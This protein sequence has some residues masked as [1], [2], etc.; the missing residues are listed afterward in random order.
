MEK[1][2]SPLSGYTQFHG[3]NV[4]RKIVVI[5]ATSLVVI[6][7]VFGISLFIQQAP[8]STTTL[9]P[10]LNQVTPLNV[11]SPA[12]SPSTSSSGISPVLKSLLT[13]NSKYAGQR[14]P[15]FTLSAIKDYK[16]SS[17][18]MY[19]FTL[20]ENNLPS[21]TKWYGALINEVGALSFY[22][23]GAL[24]YTNESIT[25]TMTFQ[26]PNG[27]YD[28]LA[29]EGNPNIL[30]GTAAVEGSSISMTVNFPALYKATITEQG[31]PSGTTWSYIIEYFSG[32]FEVLNFN[33]TTSTSSVAYLPDGTYSIINGRSVAVVPS[34]S[35]LIVN[36]A[37]VSFTD[38]VPT[39]YKT[40][41]FQSDLGASTEWALSILSENY[42]STYANIS[43]SSSM[44]AYLPN[45]TYVLSGGPGYSEYTFDIIQVNGSAQSVTAVFPHMYKVTFVGNGVSDST[46]EVNIAK[47][48]P[49]SGVGSL[50]YYDYFYGAVQTLYLPNGTYDWAAYAYSAVYQS[51]FKVVGQNMQV[52]FQFGKMYKITFTASNHKASN[53]WEVAVES[54]V[55]S[56]FYTTTN[57][58][59]TSEIYFYLPNGTY[60]YGVSVAGIGN[61]YV[62][63]TVS[64]NSQFITVK[65]PTVYAITFT[66]T[67][68]FPGFQW[69]ISGNMG[70]TFYFD[71]TTSS[72]S[73][74]LY[75][76]NGT[77]N[78]SAF[79][80]AEIG[81][82]YYSL[83]V[84]GGLYTVSGATHT[85]S[86]SF[87]KLYAVTF[88]LLNLR[89]GY[90]VQVNVNEGSQYVDI[91][92][93]SSTGSTM[94]A[95]LYNGTF[96][97]NAVEFKTVEGYDNNPDFST[98]IIGETGNSFNVTGSQLKLAVKLPPLYKVSVSVSG[99]SKG[100][101]WGIYILN[102]NFTVDCFNKATGSSLVFMIPNGSYSAS[103]SYSTLFISSGQ[104]L[105][106]VSGSS[107]SISY[108][109]PSSY[110]VT[111]FEPY[112]GSCVEW[113][114]QVSNLSS[115]TSVAS[116]YNYTHNISL[117]LQNGTYGINVFSFDTY[118]SSY[119][120]TLTVNGAKKTINVIFNNF[121]K[122]DVTETGLPS[123]TGWY[124]NLSNV[125]YFSGELT[126]SSTSF[127]LQNGSYFLT[128][129]A[130][131]ILYFA[132]SQYVNVSGSSVTISVSFSLAYSYKV[133]FIESGL[134]SNTKWYINVTG[135]GESSS[136]T[137]TITVNLPNGTFTYTLSN[138]TDY[139]ANKY[140]GSV[141][142]SGKDTSV[143]VSYL[144]YAYIEGSVSPAGT[145]I[146][147]NGNQ[148]TVSSGSFNASV[149]SGTYHLT[150]TKGG[151][152]TF[153]SNFTLASGH[154][155]TI[156]VTLKALTTTPIKTASSG[157][158]K[159]YIIGGV[160][161]G[162][163]IIGAV[164]FLL[165]RK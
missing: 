159:Y 153:Y 72:S 106:T 161:A 114:I 62:Q 124:M 137:S 79:E 10:D 136:S 68:L 103:F 98:D 21:G 104:R 16:Q 8:V 158:S 11:S 99:L 60:E 110:E 61:S 150:G 17:P 107:T 20:K 88:N 147:I 80:D 92:Q 4:R 91:F 52:H 89:A 63:L 76:S 93:N 66:E 28:F 84:S 73:M 74:V 47:C 86:L 94:T 46:W 43:T 42:S 2:D 125:S 115:F 13:D 111:F 129:E 109:F 7:F 130:S 83:P 82:L 26:V 51:E 101:V 160:I 102:S 56:F 133:S 34:R 118:Y 59:S 30:F 141:T 55:G 157:I 154:T 75:A 18:G 25:S 108:V 143:S 128:P 162:I 116:D 134:P 69:S 41:I 163:V 36:G 135:I 145:V 117:D 50:N 64:G 146:T 49:V 165:R 95:Y 12:V 122:I 105:I 37:P 148:V 142:V 123:G 155:K 70:N 5:I 77:L 19:T 6:S 31:L 119:S 45:G 29:G 39:L 40:T 156:N 53:Q 138:T 44:V 139:Y 71:N 22:Y 132:E 54:S 144:H 32:N 87:P 35:P 96:T 97:Y 27:T 126:S 152:K 3:N 65:L 131:G 23:T 1:E 112:T 120:T 78:Y 57:T 81:T 85:I 127:Y 121:Y 38:V 140:S 58:S 113:G 14:S 9:N 24:Q 67:G 15:Y 33:S 90:S 151:Y 48:S 149:P 164:V 100:E